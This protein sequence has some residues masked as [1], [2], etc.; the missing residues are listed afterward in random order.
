MGAEKPWT[1]D[2]APENYVEALKK[3][4]I[5]VEIRITRIG[6]KWKMSQEMGEGDRD[7]VEEGLRKV[8]T[9]VAVE[10]ADLVK[11]RGAA[12]DAL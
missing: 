4:I 1:V 2:M 6:G 12:K 11:K 10:V 9:E 3:A 8:G 7:G 5:G